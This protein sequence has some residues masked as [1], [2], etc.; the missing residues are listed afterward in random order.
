[1]QA[2]IVSISLGR[3]P[4]PSTRSQS[5]FRGD[6]STSLLHPLSWHISS[7]EATH[8]TACRRPSPAAGWRSAQP[9]CRRSGRW[10]SGPPGAHASAAQ[11]GR[12]SARTRRIGGCMAPGRRRRPGVWPPPPPL[13]AATCSA[14]PSSASP[15]QVGRGQRQQCRPQGCPAALTVPRRPGHAAPG[16]PPPPAACVPLRA[17]SPLA[18]APCC[19]FRCC[20]WQPHVLA[21]RSHCDSA[22]C[23]PNT[24]TQP[25]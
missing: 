6:R 22:T 1:M 14:R 17:R 8:S 4:C 11:V 7:L 3:C 2:A 16:A 13:P 24:H 9:R 21:P 18:T 23:L 5:D 10:A 19:R 25:G 20:G 15:H 12:G